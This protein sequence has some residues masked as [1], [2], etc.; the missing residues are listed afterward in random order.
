M[1]DPV[2]CLI[3]STRFDKMDVMNKTALY[4]HP[5]LQKLTGPVLR[6]GGLDLTRESAIKCHLK[7]GDR[8]LDVGCGFGSAAA[9]LAGEFSL[10]CVGIDVDVDMLRTGVGMSVAPTASGNAPGALAP[11]RKIP[12][13]QATA[14][15]L[16]FGSHS[17]KAVF[18]ECVLSLVPDM[19]AALDEFFR[20]LEPGGRLILCDLYL[21]GGYHGDALKRL[22]LACGFR[23]A[24]GK[25]DI[26]KLVHAT[27]FDPGPWED[28][29]PLLTRLAGQAV[30]E[31]GSLQKFWAAVF[32]GECGASR[33]TCDAIRASR[34]GYFRLI[35]QKNE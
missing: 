19:E 25:A 34:P 10:R 16:P 21:R 18:C 22:P 35:V 31:H 5:V 20:V 27:G 6:P 26:E 29:T 15:Q 9:L 2:A 7:P 24:V 28:L 1:P 8:V 32:G 4:Q 23:K 17:L 3:F 12:V 33:R 14:Q 11:I 13:A 30:F